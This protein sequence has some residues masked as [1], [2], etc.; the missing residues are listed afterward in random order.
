MIRDLIGVVFPATLPTVISATGLSDTTQTGGQFELGSAS[1][2]GPENDFVIEPSPASSEAVSSLAGLIATL[3]AIDWASRARASSTPSSWLV[4]VST[5]P[6]APRTRCSG[7]DRRPDAY[8]AA[9]TI[10]QAGC[11]VT[12]R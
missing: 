11:V 1:H 6:T 10:Q 2:G 4:E 7:G 8:Q 12:S 3:W 9:L 5:R